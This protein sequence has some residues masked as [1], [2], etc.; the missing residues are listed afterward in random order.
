MA[1]VQCALHGR[2][3]EQSRVATLLSSWFQENRPKPMSDS[4]R[5]TRSGKVPTLGELA[6]SDICLLWCI[7]WLWLG[8]T[9]E[10]Y[11]HFH[12]H[13]ASSG[14]KAMG[15]FD[16]NFAS[17]REL[18]AIG[19]KAMGC[20]KRLRRHATRIQLVLIVGMREVRLL[21]ELH[22]SLPIVAYHISNLVICL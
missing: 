3:Y 20:F 10:E 19:K 1:R 15:L 6:T 4:A 13:I 9:P 17:A 21:F 16:K 7:S 2:E 14:K 11:N 12:E 5:E 18:K 22:I 8:C